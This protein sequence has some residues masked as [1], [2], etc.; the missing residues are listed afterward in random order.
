MALLWFPTGLFI[1]LSSQ[2]CYLRMLLGGQRWKHLQSEDISPQD[3]KVRERLKKY[4]SGEKY[5]TMASNLQFRASSYKILLE[6]SPFSLQVLSTEEY[7]LPSHTRNAWYGAGR[8]M[9]QAYQ[10][11][12][13]QN[14]TGSRRNWERRCTAAVGAEQ[15]AAVMQGHFLHSWLVLL[16]SLENWVLT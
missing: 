14:H 2:N 3:M 7:S 11:G 9:P 8:L 16:W 13:C 5:L 4:F 12:T 6:K 15:Q 1:S 10:M